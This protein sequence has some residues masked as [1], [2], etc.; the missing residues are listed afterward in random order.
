MA[1]C[2]VGS[3]APQAAASDT[4]PWTGESAV[5]AH[6]PYQHGYTA[7]D[8]LRWEPAADTDAELLRSRVP[9]QDRI[10]ADP[11]S[12]RDP[13]LPA[14]T[15]L[16]TL[17]GDYGNA[18][19]ESHHDTDEFSQYLFSYWQYAD[20]YGTWH[21]QPTDGISP[22]WYDPTAEWTQ[23]WF[24]F[25][26]LNLPNPA[27]TNAAHRNGVRSLATIFFSDNDRGEQT[28]TD[29][30]VRGDDGRFPVAD[31][32]TEVARWFGFDGYFV[33]QEEVSRDLDAGQ[34]A[35]YQTFMQQLRADGIYVQ[36]YDSV[37]SSG[38]IGYQ[39]AF[40]AQ[41]SLFVQD[42]AAGRVSDSIFLNYWWNAA[43]LASSRSHA[44]SLGLDPHEAVF[45]GVEAGLYQFEQ[46][47]D[48]A[49]NLGAD[50]T[51]MNSI[52]ILGA[53]FVHADHPDKTDDGAQWETFDRERRWWT[54]SSTGDTA[55][56]GSWQGVSS[57]IAERSVIGGGTFSTT[58]NTGHGLEHRTA[59]TVTSDREWGNINV[60]DVPV[61]WQWWIDAADSPLQ[62]DYDYGSSSTSAPR[63]AYTP[64]GAYEGGSSLVLSGRLAA[65]NTVRL[66]KTDLA[67]DAGSAVDLTWRK[68]TTDDSTLA[69]GVVLASDPGTVVELELDDS[70]AATDGWRTGRVDLSSFAGD[71]VITLGLVVGAGNTPIEDFQVNVGA[72]RVTD[73]VDRT[74]AAPTGLTVDRLLVDSDELVVSWDLA[75]YADVR[76]YR[77]YLDGTYLGG[78]YD[79]T[80]YVKDLPAP[81]G[82]LEL[83]AVGPDGSVSAPATLVLDAATAPSALEVTTDRSGAM[84]VAW[85]PA[86]DGVPTTVRVESRASERYAD[87]PFAAETTVPA[88]TAT[89]DLDGMPL[90]GSG[91]VVTVRAGDG[92]AVAAQGH[93]TDAT[94]QQ[95]PVCDVIWA[96]PDTVTL[97]RPTI[98][99]WRYLRVEERWDDD[100]TPQT[101]RK[102]FA[103]TYSQP[104]GDQA[105]RGRTMRPA[106]TLD[107]SHV[108]SELWVALEDYAGNVTSDEP[109]GWT[110]V[111]RADEDCAPQ[112]LGPDLGETGASTLTATVGEQPAD[113]VSSHTL[114]VRVRDPFG[115]PVTGV[116]VA[117][118]LPDG[119]APSAASAVTAGDASEVVIGTGTTGVAEV[120]VVSAEAGTY[121]VSA[122]VAGRAVLNGDGAT[123]SFTA[124]PTEP[125]P[126]PEVGPEPEGERGQP[127]DGGAR[128]EGTVDALPRTGAE[129]AGLVLL[130]VAALTGGVALTVRVR[131]S[132]ARSDG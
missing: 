1:A 103:Y 59:G 10:G 101:D 35:D 72:L 15:Q 87:A 75:D 123:V 132:Q 64:V 100:G 73:G 99:D 104:A 69:V 66:Y 3:A 8:L 86:D 116:D 48:L 85:T 25:G 53:D 63:F 40:N 61:T 42:S 125:T 24:E 107:L 47:Y 4:L 119:L 44:E 92:A 126:E 84:T 82:Q 28:F 37:T 31:K 110:R 65:D 96:D 7:S 121:A 43:R 16:H 49:D 18:F 45:A 77:L 124:L 130:A 112:E 120:A 56:D 79:E 27:Y 108:D 114:T 81:S 128:A 9:L 21:G 33:N 20:L 90:D 113:G 46:P 102:S 94:L 13:A 105:V 83:R 32:L 115:N 60:Q 11:A 127:D 22:E 95:L 39:N 23:R 78:R 30:L 68:A 118:V 55:A 36:W 54:G 12:Q 5:G 122:S 129:I 17:A 89:A 26:M 62:A 88:G 106:Y 41:N 111:P 52:A 98:A 38:S 117:F 58:F 51:P 29:L 6:Q 67:V 70:D 50:G 91:Y 14:S 93:F 74:P 76:E 57:Y 80:L 71:R 2:L 19:F 34:I 131:R 97:P 109:A